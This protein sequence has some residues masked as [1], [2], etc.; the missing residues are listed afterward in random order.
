[1]KG[2][3]KLPTRPLPDGV[4]VQELECRPDQ[5]ALVSLGRVVQ[6]GVAQRG[7]NRRQ[8][9]LSTAAVAEGRAQ[10][11]PSLPARP[12]G[13][14]AWRWAPGPRTPSRGMDEVPTDSGSLLPGSA[15]A[16]WQV[17]R[18]SKYRTSNHLRAVH[19]AP[20]GRAQQRMWK[21]ESA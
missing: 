7:L 12:P 17:P 1:M 6:G 10:G 2:P 9:A 4:G 11:L 18:S 14:R 3:G 5:L 20:G 21:L 16:F 15:G 8:R 19:E 13:L